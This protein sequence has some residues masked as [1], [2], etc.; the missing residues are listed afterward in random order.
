[1]SQLLP[2]GPVDLTQRVRT[3]VN[4]AIVGP[5]PAGSMTAPT[6]AQRVPAR[7]GGQ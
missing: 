3:L 4:Q 6:S 7:V 1:M 5:A 2:A